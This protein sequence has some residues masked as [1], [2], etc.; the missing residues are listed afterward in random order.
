MAVDHDQVIGTMAPEAAPSNPAPTPDRALSHTVQ[1]PERALWHPVLAADALHHEVP[2]AVRLLATDIALWRA[3]DGSPR[4]FADRCPHRGTRLSLGRVLGGQIECAYHGWRF[5]GDGRCTLIPAAPD[6][7]PP[8]SHAACSFEAIEAHELIWVR[9]QPGEQGL[10]PFDAESDPQLRKLLCG[11]YAV[12]A[13]APRIVEN[14]LDL[15]H[16]G[17]V[18]EQWLGDRD[19]TALADYSIAATAQGFAATGCRAWQPRSN[20]LSSEGCWVD[21][22]Y[23][24]TAPYAAQLIK[25]PQAQG[26]YRDVIGLFV[27]PVDPDCSVVWFRLAVTDFESADDELRA[28]QHR[29]F[30]QDQPILESQ[31]PAL[32]PVYQN[33]ELHHA[34]DRASA[35]YRRYLREHDITFGTC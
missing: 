17:F 5:A 30:S 23:E 24:L 32:L 1:S 20:R 18:H 13:S 22:R 16:F 2:V 28:F 10:P 12:Q 25:L 14:F 3:A 6:F 19:H 33:I 11:P 4:A 15:A 7:V 27:C 26:D 21:Y 35:A 31:Q 34:A 9:L 29:I 8:T